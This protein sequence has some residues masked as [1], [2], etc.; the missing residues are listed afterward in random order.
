MS[1]FIRNYKPS[2]LA[3][4][5]K[6][7]IWRLNS[8]TAESSLKKDEDEEEFRVLDIIK[9]RDK[10]QRRIARRTDTQPD[11]ADRMRENQVCIVVSAKKHIARKQAYFYAHIISM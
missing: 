7:N 5:Y 2:P 11:R 8:T 10:Q 4:I 6:S 1:I 9:K 3:T